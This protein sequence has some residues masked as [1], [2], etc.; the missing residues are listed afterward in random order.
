MT[1]NSLLPA[2]FNNFI[3]SYSENMNITNPGKNNYQNGMLAKLVGQITGDFTDDMT[4]F[5]SKGCPST[6]S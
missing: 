6:W 3:F 4:G 5:I 2:N 1:F